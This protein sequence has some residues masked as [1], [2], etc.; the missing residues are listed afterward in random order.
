MIFGEKFTFG[1][2]GIGKIRLRRKWKLPSIHPPLRSQPGYLT[3]SDFLV[4]D[5]QAR[6]SAY[7]TAE[8]NDISLT[9]W[10]TN[11]CSRNQFGHWFVWEV[12]RVYGCEQTKDKP[13]STAGMVSVE[14]TALSRTYISAKW[15]AKNKC[16]KNSLS[17]AIIQ[18]K[19]FTLNV[20][21]A[22]G[23]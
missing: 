7:R 5:H 6:F 10:K 15:I 2:S 8:R 12:L 1:E 22:K 14:R 13:T 17:E 21:T 4:L 3:R 19:N 16:A 20:R 18:R 23:K 11:F 9:T